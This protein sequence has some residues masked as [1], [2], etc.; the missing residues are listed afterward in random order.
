M[1]EHSI[2]PDH[3]L[4]TLASDRFP[5]ELL[6]SVILIAEHRLSFSS[7]LS[8]IEG[9]GKEGIALGDLSARSWR[10][11]NMSKDERNLLI[12]KLMK[13]HGVKYVQGSG[14]KSGRPRARL[15]ASGFYAGA[16]S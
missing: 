10:Y 1:S 5:E 16:A 7:V 15:V 9:S 4:E 6:A 12:V 2:S 3:I 14:G 8:C 13:D 11:R